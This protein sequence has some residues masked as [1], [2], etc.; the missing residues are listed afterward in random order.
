MIKK[1]EGV[2]KAP[3]PTRPCNIGCKSNLYKKQ[4]AK[5]QCLETF[6]EMFAQILALCFMFIQTNLIEC[7]QRLC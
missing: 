7:R 1:Q 4:R 2:K 5:I 3:L 6:S